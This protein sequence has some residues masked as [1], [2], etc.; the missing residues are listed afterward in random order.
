VFETA[1]FA[2]LRTG[3]GAVLSLLVAIYPA[4]ANAGLP[5]PAVAQA[6]VAGSPASHARVAGF[7]K[8]KLSADARRL[9]DWVTKS[10]DADGMA[11]LIVD[12]KAAQVYVFNRDGRLRAS[13]PVLLGAAVG[14]DSA[15]GIGTRALSQ[16]RPEEKTTP[17]GR[18]VA[19]RGHDARGEDVVWI[20][21]DAAVSMH[22][23]I[24]TN[25]S[26]HRLERLA[27][28]T[29]E[30]N[31]ISFGCIN[32]PAAFFE[33]HIRPTFAVYQAMVYV[34]PEVKSMREVFGVFEG[35]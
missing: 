26:E 5:D 12:K 13:S 27:S 4:V 35:Q 31:R 9:A 22:R 32:V 25:P 21:Y 28:P 19:E 14:D 24:T 17:A 16:V 10:R 23:V 11:F 7:G 34:L 15:P 29:I 18:F 30:D 2:A 3:L 33:K 6:A 8:D 1:R 20:D